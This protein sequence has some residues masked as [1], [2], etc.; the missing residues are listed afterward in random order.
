M[1]LAA[2]DSSIALANRPFAAETMSSSSWLQMLMHCR[3][4]SPPDLS[5]AEVASALLAA[6]AGLRARNIRIT[7]HEL[8]LNRH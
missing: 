5:Q 6:E 3:A 7:L 4:P 2:A 8:N 1:S